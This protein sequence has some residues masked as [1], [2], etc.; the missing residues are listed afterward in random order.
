MKTPEDWPTRPMTI[1]QLAEWAGVGRRFI[2]LEI[3]RGHLRVRRLSKRLIRI[4]P[5]DIEAWM[6]GQKA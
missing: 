3:E 2:E 1:K 6:E 5:A 4:M